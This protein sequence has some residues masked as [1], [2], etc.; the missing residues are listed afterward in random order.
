MRSPEFG[1]PKSEKLIED[2]EANTQ[3]N[4]E[5]LISGDTANTKRSD[6]SVESAD[7]SIVEGE[8][9]S[10]MISGL[11]EYPSNYHDFAKFGVSNFRCVD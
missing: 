6:N 7:Q 3:N 11:F 1:E 5:S 10:E 2:N 4:D 8:A 9:M